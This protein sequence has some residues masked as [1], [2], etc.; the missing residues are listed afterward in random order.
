LSKIP[1][2]KDWSTS[3]RMNQASV[4]AQ[5]RMQMKAAR[6]EAQKF[7]LCL[8]PS[9]TS[10]EPVQIGFIVMALSYKDA[11]EFVFA[12]VLTLLA[13]P[14]ALVWSLGCLSAKQNKLRQELRRV[15]ICQQKQKIEERLLVCM[16]LSRTELWSDESSDEYSLDKCALNKTSK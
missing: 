5:R 12:I 8:Y 2:L 14:V 1:Q 10:L 4:I 11:T 6:D 3:R 9:E 13:L 16:D 15:R 7:Q